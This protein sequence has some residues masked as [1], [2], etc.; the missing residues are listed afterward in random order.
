MNYTLWNLPIILDNGKVKL[1]QSGLSVVMETDFGLTV[2]YDWEQ[3]LVITVPSSFAG[4]VCGLCGNFNSKE[5]DD[6]TT[7]SGSMAS[8]VEALGKSWRVPGMAEDTDCRDDCTG[9]CLMCNT[10]SIQQIEHQIFCNSLLQLI[11]Q[12]FKGCPV[13][14]DHKTLLNSCMFDICRGANVKTYLCG[15]LQVYADTCQ[16]A[17]VKVQNWRAISECRE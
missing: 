8:N 11:D 14:I 6:L 13:L 4:K 1:S 7:P 5:E 10:S 16:R 3:H 2:Q 17:G 15:T 12:S 9:E